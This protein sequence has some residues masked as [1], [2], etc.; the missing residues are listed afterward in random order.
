VVSTEAASGLFSGDL[1]PDWLAPVGLT[2]QL[3]PERRAIVRRYT[4]S[5]G[6]TD[7]SNNAST[8]KTVDVKVRGKWFP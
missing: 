3:R 8:P 6:A 1:S 7:A 4:L 2:V 5:A